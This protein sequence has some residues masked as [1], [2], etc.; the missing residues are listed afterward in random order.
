MIY[1]NF[2]NFL[3]NR[4]IEFIGLILLF[5]AFLLAVSFFSYSPSDPTFIYGTDSI[6]INNLLGVYGGVVADFLLQ[7]FGLISFL[8]LITIVSWGIS[9]IVK[10][11]IKRI[12]FKIF[13]MFLYILFSCILIYPT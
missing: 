1:K 4:I 7:S 5:I 2:I 8:V 13:Y 3:K 11:K 6:K 10:K 12:K 9:L